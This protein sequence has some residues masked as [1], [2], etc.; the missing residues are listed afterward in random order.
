MKFWVEN[1]FL[2]TCSL[3]AMSFAHQTRGNPVDPRIYP[4]ATCLQDAWLEAHLVKFQM[5]D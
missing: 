2:R 4:E 3:H 1:S 5:P